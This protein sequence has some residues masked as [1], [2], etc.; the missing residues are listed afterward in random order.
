[1]SIALIAA[2][3]E[4]GYIGENNKLL[5]HIGIDFKHFKSI[6]TGHPVFMGRKTFLSIGRPLPNR[7]NI[8][9][10]RDTTFHSDGIEV[11]NDIHNII[12]EARASNDIYFCIGG[13]D[14][15][16]QILPFA[17]TL[18]I[19]HVATDVEGD[20]R[21]P[22]IDEK[23]WGKVQSET[24]TQEETGSHAIEFATYDRIK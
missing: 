3:S 2:V 11:C 10:T 12:N 7:R 14:L 21:F 17:K 23:E 8:I 6:T 1:M 24:H 15:Y 9:I 16:S 5:W 13:G 19:T 20:T 4:K 22:N 18:Y